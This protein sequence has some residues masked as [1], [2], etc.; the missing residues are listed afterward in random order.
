MKAKRKELPKLLQIPAAAS[1]PF[2]FHYSTLAAM[3]AAAVAVAG[4]TSAFVCCT[5]APA[6]LFPE[7]TDDA[8]PPPIRLRPPRF[9]ATFSAELETPRAVLKLMSRA[10]DDDEAEDKG[11][12]FAISL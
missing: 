6:S 4:G 5:I 7:T 10:V 2:I 12:F 11:D 3:C 8:L 1:L 9:G